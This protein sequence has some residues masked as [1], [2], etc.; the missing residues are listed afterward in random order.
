MSVDAKT[1]AEVTRSDLISVFIDGIEVAVPKGTLLIHL[2]LK[3]GL[4]SLDVV[5]GLLEVDIKL[6]A[7]IFSKRARLA[8]DDLG[9][10]ER[11]QAAQDLFRQDV[12]A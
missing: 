7:L 1:A 5:G 4:A 11:R 10:I 6:T 12:A 3:H 9:A 2:E 8:I